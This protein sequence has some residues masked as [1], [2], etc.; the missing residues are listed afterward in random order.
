MTQLSPEKSDEDDV[1]WNAVGEEF[2]ETTANF[3]QLFR[4]LLRNYVLGRLF[5][6]NLKMRNGSIKKEAN[7]FPQT[8]I[9]KMLQASKGIVYVICPLDPPRGSEGCSVGKKL[10]KKL[11]LSES[12]TVATLQKQ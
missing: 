10:P 7:F 3:H 8:H 1:W 6:I 5:Q 11:S 12:I 2:V 4:A 9:S